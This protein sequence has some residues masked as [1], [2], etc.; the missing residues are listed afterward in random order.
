MRTIRTAALAAMVVLAAAGAFAQGGQ[1]WGGGRGGGVNLDGLPVGTLSEA[2]ATGL[3][4]TREEEKLARDVYTALY[5]IWEAPI[6]LHIAGSEQ[7][8]MDAI[9]ALLDRYGLTDPVGTNP[10]GVFTEATLQSLYYELL[11]KGKV[12]PVDALTVGATIED[13][14]LFD[15]MILI[16]ESDNVDLDTVYENLAKGSR[17][18]LRAFVGE[19]AAQGVTYVPQYLDAGLYQEIVSTPRERGPVDANG[20]PVAGPG[21]GGCCGGGQGRGGSGSG[22]C[23][24]TGQGSGQ[25][26]GQPGNGTGNGSG[27]GQGKP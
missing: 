15:I 17:N 2:E 25:G 14:D 20:K 16:E 19:L 1:G 6:F 26:N 3:V 21:Q 10:A 24:G 22:T 4:F 9:K 18:H 13:L 7:R 5:E 11:E 23:D 12:T 8:H 27:N